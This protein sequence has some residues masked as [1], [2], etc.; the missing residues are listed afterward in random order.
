MSTLKKLVNDRQTCRSRSHD[1]HVER[2]V[3]GEAICV[4]VDNHRRGLSIAL[5]SLRIGT[6]GI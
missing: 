5:I 1:A 4:E 2:L 3:E 6:L